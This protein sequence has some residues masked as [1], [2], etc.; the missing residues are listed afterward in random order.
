MAFPS[1]SAP[2]LFIYLF[3]PCVLF[4]QEQLRVKTFEMGGWPH[5]STADHAYLLEVVSSGSIMTLAEIPNIDVVILS[6]SFCEL[7]PVFLG[8]PSAS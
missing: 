3:S 6:M 1:V 5:S 4:R 8:M 2:F 7:F